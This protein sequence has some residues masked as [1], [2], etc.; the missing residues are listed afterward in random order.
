MTRA[1]RVA[2]V[3]LDMDWHDY[4]DTW[5]ELVEDVAQML[6]N[7]PMGVVDTLITRLEDVLP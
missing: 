4:A 2:S 7:D 3:L 5:A 1:D 6:A